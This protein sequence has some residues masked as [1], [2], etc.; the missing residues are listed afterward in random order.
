MASEVQ[1]LRDAIDKEV[2][3]AA[4]RA[5]LLKEWQVLKDKTS[6][7]RKGD[8]AAI[9]KACTQ[10][11]EQAAQNLTDKPARFFI[12]VVDGMCTLLV[13]KHICT[14]ALHNTN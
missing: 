12:S 6:G 1:A 8:V 4:K 13:N 9:K 7:A 10:F 2:I 11:A 14:H 3:P 5:E